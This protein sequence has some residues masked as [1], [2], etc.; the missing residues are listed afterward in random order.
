MIK[1]KALWLKPDL[2]Y[3]SSLS[4]DQN[5]WDANWRGENLEEITNSLAQTDSTLTD[6]CFEKSILIIEE[7][8]EI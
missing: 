2:G 7:N 4:R 6:Y 8:E 5:G 3:W 1:Y